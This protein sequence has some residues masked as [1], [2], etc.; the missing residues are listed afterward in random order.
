MQSGISTASN[1]PTAF[2]YGSMISDE[3]IG[4][5][6]FE[7]TCFNKFRPGHVGDKFGFEVNECATHYGEIG[8]ESPVF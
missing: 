2:S 5:S 6:R 3:L 7:L 8:V 1:G 4:D